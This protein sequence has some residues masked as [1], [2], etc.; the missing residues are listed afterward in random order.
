[1]CKHLFK[2]MLRYFF[3]TL[4]LMMFDFSDVSDAAVIAAAEAA[5]VAAVA[6]AVVPAAARA[7]VAALGT[8]FDRQSQYFFIFD[9]SII[10]HSQREAYIG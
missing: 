4:V 7:T 1:M 2:Y 5:A 9:L 10:T 8:Y 6:A 3:E